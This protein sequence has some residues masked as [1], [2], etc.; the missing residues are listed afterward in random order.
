MIKC[1]GSH[2]ENSLK[3]DRGFEENCFKETFIYGG[4][5]FPIELIDVPIKKVFGEWI[6]DIDMNELQLF[7]FKRLIYKPQLI[8]NNS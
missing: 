4:L 7:V 5:G 8:F 6:I 2:F 3:E 1:K